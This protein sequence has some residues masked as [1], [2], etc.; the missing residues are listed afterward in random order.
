MMKETTQTLGTIF[1]GVL[2]LTASSQLMAQDPVW[3]LS[4]NAPADVYYNPASPD[5]SGFAAS[6]TLLEAQTSGGGTGAL[7]DVQ[8]YS[9]GVSHDPALLAVTASEVT[10]TSPA[11]AAPDFIDGTLYS[12]G[13]TAGVVFSFTGQWTLTY[14]TP[15]ELATASYDLVNGPLTGADTPTVA[16]LAKTDALGQPPVASVVVV[17]GGSTPVNDVP[18]SVSLIPFTPEFQMSLTAPETVYYPEANPASESFSATVNLQ[19]VL[20]PGGGPGEYSAVQGVSYGVGHDET[21]LEVTGVTTLVSAPDGS[22]PD[23]DEVNLLANGMNQGLVFSFLDEWTITYET[24]EPLSSLAYQLLPGALAGNTASTA[25]TV[26]FS[27]SIGSP[28]V[29]LAIVVDGASNLP[30]ISNASL[31]LVPFT[32]SRF[33]RG[34]STQDGNLNLADG[35]GVLAYLFQGEPSTCLKAMD[36][37]LSNHVSISD[38]VQVL[39]SLFCEGSPAPSGPYPECGVDIDST[40]TCES[41]SACP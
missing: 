3:E 29:A 37:D 25:T 10:T 26:F 39:C 33:I 9:F 17:N 7:S 11:G 16:T 35:I 4:V 38:G 15:T 19:E 23:F 1:L 31:D 30:T 22:A 34:D 8:G 5:A 32:G 41:F 21:L 28:P 40:L 13:F 6:V 12:D 36:M 20:L 14:G 18:A 24:A 2:L 27:D